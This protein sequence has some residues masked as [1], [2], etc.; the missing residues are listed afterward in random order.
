MKFQQYTLGGIVELR[1]MESR[2]FHQ[3]I[4]DE[5]HHLDHQQSIVEL[6][7]TQYQTVKMKNAQER[8]ILLSWLLVSR[9]SNSSLFL[10]ICLE[11]QTYQLFV[12]QIFVGSLLDDCMY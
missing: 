6:W 1:A 9:S 3:V 10:M 4:D 11:K 8:S 12:L 7:E 2:R 5:I